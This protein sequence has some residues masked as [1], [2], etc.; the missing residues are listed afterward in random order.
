MHS[1]TMRVLRFVNITCLL[2][3]SCS[4]FAPMSSNSLQQYGSILELPTTTASASSPSPRTTTKRSSLNL[5][6]GAQEAWTAYNS[7]LEASPLLVKSVTASVILGAADLT[8][9]ALESQQ[10]EGDDALEID[11]ARTVRFAFFGLVLQAPWNHY[12]Y[13]LLD[14]TIPPTEEPW[15][16]TN[17]IKV[18][19]DQFIQA[20]IFTV[21]IF[22]FLGLLEGKS[23]ESI[24]N[25]LDEDYVDTMS[26]NCKF[27]FFSKPE[28]GFV[29]YF[30]IDIS[31]TISL[32]LSK[33]REVVDPSYH[34]EY[35][36]CS[37]HFAS[38]VFE[39]RLLLLV[40]FPIYQTQ[41]GRCRGLDDSFFSSQSEP[42]MFRRKCGR[43]GRI[44]T[45]F[46][47]RLLHHR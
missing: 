31:Q 43:R 20:P 36:I 17:G 19:I 2:S 9:Q 1:F 13:N 34:S 16:A 40:H 44:P 22:A 32:R 38:A 37:S 47:P 30:D 45:H 25:Q 12:Y 4:A 6:A 18:A 21:L 15:S 7:A 26:A 39:L 5:V 14:G 28:N 8:G 29:Y 41:Q 11:I 35:C 27:L 23:V 42:N 24:K 10:K 33:Y 3:A 46:Q